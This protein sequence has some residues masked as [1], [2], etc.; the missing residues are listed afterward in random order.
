MNGEPASITKLPRSVIGI[1][2]RQ[3]D[4]GFSSD[5]T[6]TKI[7]DL[8]MG[9]LSDGTPFLTQ[10]G[11]ASL[12]GVENAHIGTISSQWNDQIEK[13]RIKKI[14]ELIAAHGEPISTA[15]IEVKSGG[16]V[17]FAYREEFSLAVL[18]YYAFEAGQFRQ[19]EALKHY[20]LLAGK[21]LREFIYQIIGYNREQSLDRRWQPFLDRVSCAYNAVPQGFFSIFKEISEMVVTL[22][23]NGVF[24]DKSVLP[25]ISV[26]LTWSS[27]WK[28]NGLAIQF[29]NRKEYVHNYPDYFPQAI[30]NPQHPFCYPDA[31]LPAFRLWFRTSY[32]EGG[33]FRT[34]IEGQLRLA[35][36]SASAAQ[37]AIKSYNKPT[38]AARSEIGL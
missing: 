18:E 22:G 20:R 35:K 2:S 19:A 27:H 31:A 24:M 32:L 14:R 9:V 15:H 21:G 28:A 4:F 23:E 11:L 7:N 25:D 10:R 26:G 29:G 36:I 33:K 13:P 38:L 12:C 17:F 5:G 1:D 30:S 16:R 8:G 6:G 3:A 34:Y 37:R